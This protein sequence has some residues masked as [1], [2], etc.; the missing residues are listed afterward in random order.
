MTV[1]AKSIFFAP[2]EGIT[3]ET[4]RL[5]IEHLYP[6]WDGLFTDFLRIPSTSSY[7]HKKVLTHF[8]DKA[9]KMKGHL[10]KTTYQILCSKRSLIGPTLKHII[11][12]GFQSL[13]LNLGC[14]SDTVNKNLGGAYLLS[15]LKAL[16]LILKTI[17]SSFQGH[18]SVKMRTG[19]L[20]TILFTDLLKCI[21][22]NGVEAI[23][24]HARTKQ[25][26][27]KGVA[28]WSYIEK[29]VNSVNIPVIGNGDIW[30]PS[31][32]EKMF[33]QTGC[34][35]VMLGRGAMKTPWMASLYKSYSIEDLDDEFLLHKRKEFIPDYYYYLQKSY[36]NRGLNQDL[37][38]KRFKALGRFLFDDFDN[39]FD[40]KSSFLR[41]KTLSEFNERLNFA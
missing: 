15:D 28:D 35:G 13:D 37:I 9:Y 12:L 25:Q 8:G 3:D 7:S 27:Y 40:L 10:E 19:Y 39:G 17:R 38:L 16:D 6:E 21:E 20:D 29:A 22:D 26:L 33:N 24:L 34:H 30:R 14:P 41:S 2:L 11:D 4:Y 36:E 5:C 18:F 1:K 32:I 31:D 23:T